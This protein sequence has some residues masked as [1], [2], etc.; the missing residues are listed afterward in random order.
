[1][2][3][4]GVVQ[5]LV[6]IL[7]SGGVIGAIVAIMK[8][9]PE[10]GQIAV[11]AANGAIVVQTGV[12]DTLRKEN[13]LLRERMEDLESKVALLGDLQDRVKGLEDERRKLKAE[14]TRLRGR[15]T[16]LEERLITLGHSP[17]GKS[18]RKVQKK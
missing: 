6:A 8:V 4:D 5:V 11:D 17:N 12:I 16:H 7:G 2:L 10:A 1:M 3:T 13:Q 15:V 18:K 14:N 9:R